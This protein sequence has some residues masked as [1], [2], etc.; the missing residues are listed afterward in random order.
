[1]YIGIH[2]NYHQL[3]LS[4]LM[5]IEFSREI[6]EKFQTSNFMKIC[7]VGAKLFHA[8]R[9]TD[10]TK[11]I[12]ACNNFGKAPK[13]SHIGKFSVYWKKSK[14]IISHMLCTLQRER[15]KLYF[16]SSMLFPFFKH[17]LI[18]LMLTIFIC[19]LYLH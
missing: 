9:Q 7:P 2:A 8:N 1:M 10:T 4:Y 6:F 19:L 11:L 16:F 17:V 18:S 12:V 5:K 15:E 14:I 13:S 3:F